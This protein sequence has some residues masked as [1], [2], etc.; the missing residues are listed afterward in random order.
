MKQ[1]A[2]EMRQTLDRMQRV[3]EDVQARRAARTGVPAGRPL[4]PGRAPAAPPAPSSAGAARNLSFLALLAALVALCGAALG[5]SA[6]FQ[7]SAGFALLLNAGRG[8]L[9]AFRPLSAEPSSPA[10][11]PSLA[12]D[13]V[14]ELQAVVR[15]LFLAL[16][17]PKIE[18]P[19]P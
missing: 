19:E 4:S 16:E 18:K 17:E 2:Q 9:T 6:L 13:E 3:L 14:R 12:G 1:S 11:G 10:A 8:L 7:W 15:T 5:R